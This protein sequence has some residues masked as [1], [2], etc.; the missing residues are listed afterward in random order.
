VSDDDGSLSVEDFEE[1]IDVAG[2]L[3]RCSRRVEGPSVAPAVVPA[4][5]DTR[6]ERVS[7]PFE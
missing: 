7:D 2:D 6:A 4:E 5:A 3:N 1:I